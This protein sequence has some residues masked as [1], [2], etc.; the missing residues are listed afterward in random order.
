MHTLHLATQNIGQQLPDKKGTALKPDGWAT[1]A[2]RYGCN[3]LYD[4]QLTGM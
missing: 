4:I 1:V 2:P 3:V